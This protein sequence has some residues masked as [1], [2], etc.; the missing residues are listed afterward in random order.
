MNIVVMNRM[1]VLYSPMHVFMSVF[2][3]RYHHDTSQ[4]NHKSDR[5]ACSGLLTHEWPC[6]ERSD[7]RRECEYHLAARCTY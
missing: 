7:E 6:S 1:D 5:N 4:R 2:R 3:R